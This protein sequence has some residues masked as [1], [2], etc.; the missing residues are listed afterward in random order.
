[1]RR[2]RAEQGL[3]EPIDLLDDGDLRGVVAIGAVARRDSIRLQVTALE[4]R[5][6]HAILA[7]R[8]WVDRGDLDEPFP[9]IAVADGL[10]TVYRVEPVV[11]A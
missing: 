9:D 3:P 11:T 6:T 5:T 1:M 10:G 2:L 4:V 8:L 7:C